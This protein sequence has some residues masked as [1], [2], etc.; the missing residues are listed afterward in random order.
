MV[1]K[2]RKE[3]RAT[4]PIVVESDEEMDSSGWVRKKM[5]N[6]KS[7]DGPD[8]GEKKGTRKI[9]LLRDAFDWSKNPNGVLKHF[10]VNLKALR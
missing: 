1:S 5:T 10:R 4:D 6:G 3:G 9:S 2:V 8:G 7:G